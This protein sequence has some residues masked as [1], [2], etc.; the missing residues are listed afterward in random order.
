MQRYNEKCNDQNMVEVTQVF[1][2]VHA[3]DVHLPS[4]FMIPITC[5]YCINSSGDS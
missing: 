2:S 3:H 5:Y 4:D 1:F